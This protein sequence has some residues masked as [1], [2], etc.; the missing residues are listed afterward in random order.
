[1]KI[2]AEYSVLFIV[3]DMNFLSVNIIDSIK[4]QPLKTALLFYGSRL[5]CEKFKLILTSFFRLSRTFFLRECL[6]K[7]WQVLC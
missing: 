3:R 5:D 2:K 1:M 7:R 4:Q 6:N